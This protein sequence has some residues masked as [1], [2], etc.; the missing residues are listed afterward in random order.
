MDTPSSIAGLIPL[1]ILGAPVVWLLFWAKK[2]PTVRTRHE[3][4]SRTVYPTSAT[5]FDQNVR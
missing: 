2:G 3:S 4:D 1:W 5:A